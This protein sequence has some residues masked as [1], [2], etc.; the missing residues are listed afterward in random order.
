MQHLADKRLV[1]TGRDA[2]GA[3]TVEVVHEALI[4]GW[5][6]LRDWMEADRAFR[7][8]QE[9]LRAAMRPVGATG[10]DEGALLRGAPLAEAEGW[11]VRAGG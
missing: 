1:V 3:E 5:G 4:Q 9:R 11:L 6:Q 10:E 8:W 2:A 7:T